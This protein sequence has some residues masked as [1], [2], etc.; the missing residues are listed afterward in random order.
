[1]TEKPRFR[2]HNQEFW[3]RFAFLF[4]PVAVFVILAGVLLHV[5]KRDEVVDAFVVEHKQRVLSV[6]QQMQAELTLYITDLLLVAN[7]PEV[8]AL[9]EQPTSTNQQNLEQFFIDLL[10]SKPSFFQ[11][12]FIRTDG[13][14]LV[15][16]E[17]EE[18]GPQVA[19]DRA[20]R[21]KT[22]RYYVREVMQL[23]RG[24][25]Y[26]SSLDLNMEH[27]EIERPLRPVIRFATP[28]FD[29]TGNRRGLV[30][31]NLKARVLLDKLTESRTD[32]LG[33]YEMVNAEGYW[34]QAKNPQHTFGFMFPNMQDFTV[35]NQDSALWLAIEKPSIAGHHLDDD[36]LDVFITFDPFPTGPPE[37]A[38]PQL[39]LQQPDTLTSHSWTL[40]SHIPDYNLYAK[41]NRF[42]G[43]LGIGLGILLFIHFMFS[44][45]TART[46]MM[47]RNAE[48]QQQQL[49]SVQQ[50]SRAVAHEFRQ[51]LSGL[52]TIADLVNMQG[53]D[54]DAA[55]KQ[56]DRIPKLVQR[57]EELV[58][59][60][61]NVTELK[62]KDYV[63][64]VSMVDLWQKQLEKQP[65]DGSGDKED[66]EREEV[67][68]RDDA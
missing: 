5:S 3:R 27:G 21:D 37:Q 11:A 66:V 19:P 50:L 61:L 31:L 54:S 8:F 28:I 46:L 32:T 9:S 59:R 48:L 41:A 65:S 67:P 17:L 55:P 60:L 2:T 38:F 22:D 7:S 15:C 49:E 6:Q 44:L 23:P 57:M 34:V 40:I 45:I 36:G 35:A 63:D 12:R 16:V 13:R 52:Q 30:I 25:V 47:R 62:V 39:H 58:E 42:T 24:M 14:E 43:R 1:M 4:T 26:H 51:P 29:R 64:G 68:P 20:K 18:D 56:L 10:G 33:Y 53:S